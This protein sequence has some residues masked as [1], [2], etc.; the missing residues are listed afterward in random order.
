MGTNPSH[1][2]FTLRHIVL[3]LLI[4]GIPVYLLYFSIWR[5]KQVANDPMVK[6]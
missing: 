5:G 2:L 1:E 3:I 4:E 6:A